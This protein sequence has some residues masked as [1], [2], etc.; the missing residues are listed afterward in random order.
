MKQGHHD[1]PLEVVD[2]D[3]MRGKHPVPGLAHNQCSESVA[4]TTGERS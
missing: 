4:A 2:S 1:L 3:E